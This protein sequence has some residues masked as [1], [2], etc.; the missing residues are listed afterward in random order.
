MRASSVGAVDESRVARPLGLMAVVSCASAEYLQR[1]GVPRSVA[2]LDRHRLVHYAGH[3][4]QRPLGFEYAHDGDLLLKPMRGA[5]TVNSGDSA[6]ACRGV[7][8]FS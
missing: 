5:V 8:A 3:F 4:G 2:E 1:H 7:P 6:G